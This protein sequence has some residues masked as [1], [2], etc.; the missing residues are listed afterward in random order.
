MEKK[1]L[2]LTPYF[3]P[4]PFPINTFVNELIER[5]DISEVKV[6]TC[7]PNYRKYGFYKGYS[8]L[9]PYVENYKKLKI[10]RLP[11][12]PRLSNSK[13]FILLFYLSF[14]VSSFTKLSPI[15]P[16]AMATD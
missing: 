7:L 1:I 10:L 11:I 3:N 16:T 13:F 14:F 2:I 12:I 6:I 15:S 9:G 4:E 8:I 5:E